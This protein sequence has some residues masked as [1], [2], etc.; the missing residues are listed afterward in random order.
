MR[1]NTWNTLADTCDGLRSD[2]EAWSSSEPEIP[3]F[4]IT[5][6]GHERERPF[7]SSRI[8]VPLDLSDE[9]DSVT[10]LASGLATT[11]GAEIFVLLHIMPIT[12]IDMER[13]AEERTS[14]AADQLNMLREDQL[15]AR[16]RLLQEWA[17]L[18]GAHGRVR[19]VLRVGE[20]SRQIIAAAEGMDLIVIYLHAQGSIRDRLLGSVAERVIRLAPCPVLTLRPGRLDIGRGWP[21]RPDGPNSASAI[22]L[23]A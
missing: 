3:A 19:T 20:L 23:A 11:H 8:L 15:P 10:E 6:E 9:S 21:P 2:G 4:D 18:V 7:K 5:P 17:D 16:A 1:S 13:E 14:A 22:A 12:P